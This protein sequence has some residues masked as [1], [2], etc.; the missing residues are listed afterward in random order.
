MADE[1]SSVSK[2]TRDGK[3]TVTIT[4]NEYAPDNVVP[5]GSLRQLAR[6]LEELAANTWAAAEEARGP[7]SGTVH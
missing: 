6:I 2:T 4:V 3:F 5:V 1:E 7:R